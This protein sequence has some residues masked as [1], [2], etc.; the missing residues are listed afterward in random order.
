MSRRKQSHPKPLKRDDLWCGE[1][2]SPQSP[3]G[4]NDD[5]TELERLDLR[6]PGGG[7]GGSPTLDDDESGDGPTPSLDADAMIDND[8][9]AARLASL[10]RL[11]DSR[12]GCNDD[13]EEPR[14]VGESPGG[15]ALSQTDSVGRGLKKVTGGL[16]REESATSGGGGSDVRGNSPDAGGIGA[17]P[18]F[19]GHYFATHPATVVCVEENSRIL[20]KTGGAY[21]CQDCGIRFSSHATLEAHQAYYC[22]R[23]LALATEDELTTAGD[24]P[25]RLYPVRHNGSWV[26]VKQDSS[27]AA[28]ADSDKERGAPAADMTNRTAAAPHSSPRS[29]KAVS[30]TFACPHCP[31]MTTKKPAF[32]QHLNLH[33][34]GPGGSPLPKVAVPP[35]ARYCSNCDIQFSSAKTFHVHKQYYCSTRHILKPGSGA[36]PPTTKQTAA[37]SASPSGG[38][39]ALPQQRHVVASSS[40]GLVR[41]AGP[42]VGGATAKENGMLLNSSV[43]SFPSSPVIILPCSYISGSNMGMLPAGAAAGLL[44]P[45]GNL[46]AATGLFPT[47]FAILTS[48]PPAAGLRAALS[49]RPAHPL[50]SAPAPGAL[51]SAK[52]SS[53]LPSPTANGLPDTKGEQPLDLSVRRS[54]ESRSYQ[55]PDA[56]R[57][58]SSCS[59]ASDSAGAPTLSMVS[60]TS[61][62]V[63][64]ATPSPTF[65]TAGGANQAAIFLTPIETAHGMQLYAHSALA[66]RLAPAPPPVKQGT[67]KCADCG[68]VFYKK[69]NYLVHRRH[70][71]S[72]RHENSSPGAGSPTADECS[73]PPTRRRKLDDAAEAPAN[74]EEVAEGSSTSKAPL[75]REGSPAP[76]GANPDEIDPPS[77]MCVAKPPPHARY[78]CTSCGIPYSSLGNLQAH[79]TYYCYCLKRKEKELLLANQ[80]TAAPGAVSIPQSS[81]GPAR[82]PSIVQC[83]RCHA[84]FHV[85]EEEEAAA[86]T[87]NLK[88]PLCDA[89]VPAQPPRPLESQARAYHCTLC[90]YRGNTLRGMKTHIRMHLERGGDVQEECY[91]SCLPAA[92][93]EGPATPPNHISPGSHCD[94]MDD[95]GAASP[96]SGSESCGAGEP[97]T[98]ATLH[99]CDYCG[100][101]SSYKGNVV[102]HV[103]LVHKE[104]AAASG[105]ATELAG[106]VFNGG[107]ATPPKTSREEGSGSPPPPSSKS[108]A[109]SCTSS[110]GVVAAGDDS[111]DTASPCGGE[112]DGEAPAANSVPATDGAEDPPAVA[113]AAKSP[114]PTANATALVAAAAANPKNASAVSANRRTGSKYCK[115]CDI[116]FTYLST[117]IAHK[118]FYCASHASE[119]LGRE[120]PVQ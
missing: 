59:E 70:Y 3:A 1:S 44:L 52:T 42:D 112:G 87:L 67:N 22:S 62:A 99:S 63:S 83:G 37:P 6:D 89:G 91:I 38:P 51:H 119:N 107:T 115:S 85:T 69:E 97:K 26:G 54:T 110:N 78:T 7:S 71:C 80:Q 84:Q 11:A 96:R 109:M 47:T 48:P 55:T 113:C 14:R 61:S 116:S 74:A 50:P 32:V 86:A 66:T 23:R 76:V 24:T 73:S 57:S 65:V 34:E 68:I 94:P 33:Q 46:S 25:A 100:Y 117:F 105:A 8:A 60:S 111:R 35:A 92:N 81:K 72:R 40:K 43:L 19:P 88:C 98:A 53:G 36:A 39:T 21:Y 15:G 9:N 118:K 17:N 2:C 114:I 29:S 104:L 31:F 20:P 82:A 64:S 93:G 95:D 10:T 106:A 56:H 108:P 120:T 28:A 75:Q 45:N 79:Q 77:S 27:P 5:G 18:G 90:G 58:P 12:S 16:P 101:T 41:V 103:R 49:P 4:S 102:R 13:E 30:R